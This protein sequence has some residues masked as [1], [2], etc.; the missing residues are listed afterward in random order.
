MRNASCLVIIAFVYLTVTMLSI[1]VWPEVGYG[2][3][4]H[5]LSLGGKHEGHYNIKQLKRAVG[6]N[7]SILAAKTS[8]YIFRSSLSRATK[9]LE[10]NTLLIKRTTTIYGRAQGCHPRWTT[11]LERVVLSPSND[12]SMAAAR[13]NIWETTHW[14]ED[15]VT[16]EEET[17]VELLLECH[18]YDIRIA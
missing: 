5:L 17:G 2:T 18:N 8:L 15:R 3:V 7:V 10:A 14:P 11:A 4:V 12:Y 9:Y 6:L 1:T 13:P 16:E